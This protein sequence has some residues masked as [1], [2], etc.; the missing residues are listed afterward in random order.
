MKRKRLALMATVALHAAMIYAPAYAA[1]ETASQ[2]EIQTAIDVAFGATFTTNYIFR[3]TTQTDDDPALQGYVEASYG[4]VYAGAWASNVNFG[5]DETDN[6]EVDLYAGIRPEFGDLSLDVGY[7]RYLYDDTGDCCGE[8]Y[9]K[10]TYAFTETFSLGGEYYYDTEAKTSWAAAK[11]EVGGLP[12]D[13]AASGSIGTDFGTLTDEEEDG[14]TKYAWDAGLSKTFADETVTLD[15]RYY[16]SNQDPARI[17]GS[18]SFDTS[19][20]ALTGK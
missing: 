3:G 16:D 14:E 8:L 5:E 10:A 17:V 13:L 15:L 7:V 6:I 9:A 12:W 20:S 1:D 19:L 2:E 4:I 11:A 18:I